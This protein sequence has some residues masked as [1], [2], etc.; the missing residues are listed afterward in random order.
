MGNDV[1][2]SVQCSAHAPPLVADH[3]RRR[4]H[5]TDTAPGHRIVSMKEIRFFTRF[6]DFSGLKCFADRP[7][8]DGAVLSSCSMFFLLLPTPSLPFS[9]A[10]CTGLSSDVYETDVL[11]QD[12]VFSEFSI[13]RKVRRQ[14]RLCLDSPLFHNLPASVVVIQNGGK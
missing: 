14:K 3:R 6:G 11:C 10:V 9:A 5:Q 12:M 1:E 8:R 4:R 7:L 13:K 2:A